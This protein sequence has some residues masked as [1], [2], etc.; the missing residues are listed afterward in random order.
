MSATTPKRFP[1]ISH[2]SCERIRAYARKEPGNGN[3]IQYGEL[4]PNLTATG[5]AKCCCCGQKIVKGEKEHRFYWDF[6]GCGSWT[7]VECH[8]HAAPCESTKVD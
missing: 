4:E 2:D 5:R 1:L 6:S 7:A 3:M 8:I